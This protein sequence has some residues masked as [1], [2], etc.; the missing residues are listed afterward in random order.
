MSK[1]KE[2]SPETQAL[3]DRMAPHVASAR[4]EY[5]VLPGVGNVYDL[6]IAFNLESETRSK[7]PSGAVYPYYD[8]L[9]RH[10]KAMGARMESGGTGAPKRG[11]T[12][13]SQLIFTTS[14]RDRALLKD[15]TKALRRAQAAGVAVPSSRA[16]ATTPAL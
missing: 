10:L 9:K 16:T 5:R 8:A 7:G 14:F 12:G 3:A 2:I 15:F 6:R 13:T 1:K 11:R 4:V